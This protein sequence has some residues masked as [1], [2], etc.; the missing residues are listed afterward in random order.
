MYTVFSTFDVPPEKANEVI[1]I[2]RNRSR[3][4]DEAPGFVDFYLLQNDK[5]S[6]EITVQ[7][8]FESKE[9]YLEWVRGEDFKKIHDLEKK[10][11]DQELA[12]IVPKV[13]QFKVVAR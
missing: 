1:D 5:N 8:F 10:Y 9:S 3:I 7:L 13:G 11:P 12:Q 2:Y 4:V 6:G